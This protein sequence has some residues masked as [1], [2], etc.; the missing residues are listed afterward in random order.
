MFERGL[1][2]SDSA[3]YIRVFAVDS[4]G[5]MCFM[6]VLSGGYAVERPKRPGIG[7]A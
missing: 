2:L 6:C 3:Q 1:L 4:V 5:Q 7:S